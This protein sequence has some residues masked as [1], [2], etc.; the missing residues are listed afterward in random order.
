MNC[1]T[2][3]PSNWVHANTRTHDTLTKARSP[4]WPR[5]CPRENSPLIILDIILAFA[6]GVPKLDCPVTR[7]GDDLTVVCG[8]ADGQ[9]IGGVTDEATGG[10][11]GVKIPKTEGV[12]PGRGENELA[13]GGDDDVRHEVVV[14]VEDALGVSVLLVVAGELPDNDSLVYPNSLSNRR[15]RLQ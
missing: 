4:F 11:A 9:D 10:E 8:E 15:Q 13:V 2:S 3:S 5:A 6:Q 14:A 12:V 1:R 7:T